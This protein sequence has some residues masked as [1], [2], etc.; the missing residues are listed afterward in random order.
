[1]QSNAKRNHCSFCQNSDHTIEE[2]EILKKYPSINTDEL[3][4]N[5]AKEK[6]TNQKF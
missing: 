3:Q 4:H 5:A 2:C 1:M 6:I